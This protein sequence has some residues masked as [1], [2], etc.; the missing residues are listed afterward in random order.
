MMLHVNQEIRETYGSLSINGLRATFVLPE[1]YYAPTLGD[2][3]EHCQEIKPTK[4]WRFSSFGRE[5]CYI[6]AAA[7]WIK[8]AHY[9]STELSPSFLQEGKNSL[10]KGIKEYL[11]GDKSNPGTKEKALQGLDLVL[12]DLLSKSNNARLYDIAHS[13]PILAPEDMR[14]ALADGQRIY[15]VLIFHCPSLGSTLLK[16]YSEHG[17]SI[18]QRSY[19]SASLLERLTV[20][21]LPSPV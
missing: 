12:K 16:H 19:D 2:F 1:I 10:M 14:K 18:L 8:S 17:S 13:H 4:G 7:V 20:I 3:V 15:D 21:P 6:N 11:A 9:K 5:V